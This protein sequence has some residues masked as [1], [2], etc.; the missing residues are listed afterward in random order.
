[1]KFYKGAITYDAFMNM[2]IPEIFNWNSIAQE[3]VAEEE[4]EINRNR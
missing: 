2:P 1:M 3:I 4:R